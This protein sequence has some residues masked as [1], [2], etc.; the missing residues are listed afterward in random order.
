MVKP[1]F[2]PELPGNLLWG[3]LLEYRRNP[4]DFAAKLAASFP[5]IATIRWG[6]FRGVHLSHPDYIRDLFVTSARKY[7]QG[8]GHSALALAL[9]Q[10]LLTSENPL[11]LHQR[12]LIQ[13]AFHRQRIA[14]YAR[15]MAQYAYDTMSSWQPGQQLDIAGEMMQLTL[16]IV[17]KTLFDTDVQ[18]AATIIGPATT[19]VNEYATLRSQQILG[20][21]WHR[22]PSP[23][24]LRFRRAQRQLNHYIDTLIAERRGEGA[25]HG[26]LFSFLV[27][28]QDEQGR[29][30]P[31][32]QIRDEAITLF[33]A[34]HE[35]TA[36]ALTWTWYLLS[37]HPEV[38]A[39]FHHELEQELGG[40]LP[41]VQDI[42]RLTY[43]DRVL[44]ESLRLY[45]PAYGT[46]RILIEEHDIGPYHLPRNTV[47][48]TFS[49]T[50]HRDPRW[51]QR[52]LVF[53]PDRWT[54]EAE[55]ARP[56]FA[57]FPFGGGQR[58]C[59]GEPFA[60][61][62]AAI[63]LA[64]IGQHWRFTLVPTHRVEPNPLITLRP[65]YGMLMTLEHRTTDLPVHIPGA[66]QTSQA[67][68]TRESTPKFVTGGDL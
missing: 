65:R 37:Q 68:W 50:V 45:P 57:Y 25:D 51:W 48:S 18:E 2:P 6:P 1:H 13:P 60:W 34:G 10:G 17:G 36:N 53:D 8:P 27:F 49:F 12:R 42:P 58:Q 15:T 30:L 61:M 66:P 38:E 56:R 54:P 29:T 55:A 39:R 20:L 32:R 16:R 46:S 9:G 43:L 67:V 4:L 14:A 11:H 3:N 5:D 40:R 23:T 26:D 62:E 44:H 7:H 47:V 52:P 63:I 24:S 31:D 22:F 41:E 64:T 35:T 21:L 28:S 33:L 19:A 59:L